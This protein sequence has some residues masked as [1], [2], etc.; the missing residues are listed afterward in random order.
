[1]A[2]ILPLVRMKYTGLA[3]TMMSAASALRY[4]S[5]L[6]AVLYGAVTVGCLFPDAEIAVSAFLYLGFGEMDGFSRNVRPLNRVE[7]VFKQQFHV[8]FFDRAAGYAEDG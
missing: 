2:A 8:A 4:I 7:H 5:C 3:S 6:R 1:M